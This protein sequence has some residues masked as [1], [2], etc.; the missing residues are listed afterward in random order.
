MQPKL[1][2]LCWNVANLSRSKTREEELSILVKDQCPDVVIISEAELNSHDTVVIQD[3]VPYFASPTPCGKRRLFILVR[4][5]LKEKTEVLASSHMDVWLRLNLSVPLTIVGVYRQWSGNEQED[6]A[7]FHNRCASFLDGNQ[8]IITGDFNL[9]FNRR[10][11][12]L[13]SRHCMASDH[14]VKMGALG[15]EYMGPYSPTYK[16]HGIY[17][18]ADGNHSHRT[19]ILDHVYALGIDT[20]N[21]SVLPIGATDH[22]PVKTV[23]SASYQTGGRKW[24][25]RRPLAKLSRQVF[26]WALEQAFESTLAELYSCKD[27]NRVHD[28]IVEAITSAL[29]EVAPYKMVPADKSNR[30]PLFLAP[31]TLQAMKERDAAAMK[32]STEYRALRN[33]V[34]RLI[35]RDRLKSSLNTIGRTKSNPRKLWSLARTFMG[36]NSQADLP[37]SLVLDSGM[38]CKNAREL[39]NEL[40]SFFITK[41]QTIREQI[42]PP[43]LGTSECQDLSDITVDSHE[44]SFCFKFPSAGKVQAIIMSL[45]N[46]GAVGVDEVP[47]SVLKLGA[48]VLA[49]PIAHLIRLS[50][51]SARVPVGFK[52]AIV[53]PVYKGKGK[54][55]KSAASY[56][57]I[58][59]L[60]A[61]SKVL[62]RCVFETLTEFL[63]SKLPAGQ[64]GF[65]KGRSTTAAIAYAHGEW[66]LIRAKGQI[67]GVLGFDLSSAFDTLDAGL[68]CSKLSNLGI[69]GRANNWFKDYLHD[70]KQCV[71]VGDARSSFRP[72]KHGV[73]QGSLL[74]PVLFL[75]MV[76]DMPKRTGLVDNPSR[77][78][79][80]YADDLCAWVSGTSIES[81]KSDLTVIAKQVSEFT[82]RNYL[83]LSAEKTQVLWS[84]L[85]R[86]TNDPA[87]DVCGSVVEPAMTIDILGAKFDR[88]L[89]SSPFLAQQHKAA[90]PIL[91]T[92]KRLARYLPQTQLAEIASAFLVGKLSYAAPATLRPRLTE[93]EPIEAGTQKLQVYINDAARLILRLSRADKIRTS[94]LLVKTGLPSLNQ[95][96][97][98][99]IAVECWHAINNGLPLGT[100][101]SGGPKSSRPTRMGSSN[102][103]APPFKFQRPSMA[104]FAVRIWNMSEDLRNA[105]T[106]GCARRVAAKIAASCPL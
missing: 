72:V 43:S 86:C 74:G 38:E 30:P 1:V 87:V 83:S 60:S 59:I 36:A 12:L 61:M 102:L 57:P 11:D 14:F 31:D 23:I 64:H 8:T 71:V 103:L 47:V 6:L 81:V 27:V 40:N 17:K 49:G 105:P 99:G 7:A 15:L 97:V 80:A 28:S 62:E 91:A 68:L 53:R 34:C 46:T 5:Q 70:R 24:V 45:K 75:A 19:S 76:A 67:L 41:I 77:G 79:V 98:R 33:K 89:T 26:C 82:K 32:H 55:M 3:Y 66:S 95:L 42:D 100:V 58:A 22:M 84:G 9:D 101:I 10:S 56:R 48:S 51:G 52:S 78:Y 2:I 35:R 54:S 90:G 18:S 29:N 106:L 69:R 25:A 16:S 96:L 44:E 13:Y 4:T 37:V 50:F 94:T 73:P 21:V 85:P 39:A 93:D 88:N 104:W 20:V 63:E 92:V 65:R